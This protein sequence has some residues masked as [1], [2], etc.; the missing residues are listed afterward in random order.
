[1]KLFTAQA[2]PF[3]TVRTAGFAT[4]LATWV[5]KLADA[6]TCVG[7]VLDIPEVLDDPQ[8]QDRFPLYPH[9]KH[10]ADMLPFPARF[11]DALAL[12]DATW[13]RGRGWALWKAL[14]T[15]DLSVETSHN[16]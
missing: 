5:A 15:D 3:A 7:P 16:Q 2:T 14:V 8:F 13:A 12:D 4:D 1:V 10:G 9:E 11:R 6:D